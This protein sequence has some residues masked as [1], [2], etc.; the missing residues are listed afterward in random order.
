M[1]DEQGCFRRRSTKGGPKAPKKIQKALATLQSVV[2]SASVL[3]EFVCT[4]DG[5]SDESIS[6]A[7]NKPIKDRYISSHS[8]FHFFVAR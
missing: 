2:D 6:M 1:D 4:E 8:T 3:C 7:Y 5:G